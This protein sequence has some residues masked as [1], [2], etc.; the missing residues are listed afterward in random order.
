MELPPCDKYT[1]RMLIGQGPKRATPNSPNK[2]CAAFN[3]Q[4]DTHV[5]EIQDST[6]KFPFKTFL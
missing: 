5:L 4:E 3:N 2:Q 1:L 6:T